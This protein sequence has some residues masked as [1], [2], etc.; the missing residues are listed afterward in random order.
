M[1]PSAHAS[2]FEVRLALNAG[3]E[4]LDAVSSKN[5]VRVAVHKAR[6]QHL[7]AAINLARLQPQ[8]FPLKRVARAHAE[9]FLAARQNAA[10]SHDPQFGEVATAPW[11]APPGE[12]QHLPSVPEEERRFRHGT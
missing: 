9:N 8:C 7:A 6:H 4:V 3:F 10:R 2:D 12:C 11:E 1:N 5:Q